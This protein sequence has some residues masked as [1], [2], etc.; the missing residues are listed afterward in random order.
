MKRFYKTA[1]VEPAGPDSAGAWR[2]TLDGRAIRTVGRRAQ[3]LPT[4]KLAQAL[5]AEWEA[6]G[7]EID[8]ES[9][10]LR[11]LADFAIDLIGPDR[12]AA[13]RTILAFGETDTLCYRA[14]EGEALHER[15][16]AVWEPLLL[17]AERRWDIRFTRIGG[18]IHRPQPTPTLARLEA[19][20]AA[21]DNFALAALQNVASLA[22]SL[23]IGLAA[24][25]PDA[26]P[27]SLWS[28]ANLEEDWQAE[29]W[30][31]DAEAMALREKRF[32]AFAAAMRFAALA[33]QEPL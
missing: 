33:R 8:P 2:V 18:V 22:A 25:E 29:L 30:G 26:D 12:A 24:L 5:A 9:F 16:L 6:Q 11:D 19:V 32:G 31:K 14:E 13:V 28:A 27:H 17:A 4:R 3:L 15:Q 23:V 20:L 7:D 1:A 10:V 21:R